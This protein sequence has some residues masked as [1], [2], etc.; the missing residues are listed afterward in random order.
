MLE[1]LRSIKPTPDDARVITRAVRRAAEFELQARIA[2]AEQRPD[3]AAANRSQ[4]KLAIGR[5]RRVGQAAR[6]DAEAA[7]AD[8]VSQAIDFLEQ[9]AIEGGY[10][11]LDLA[12]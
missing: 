10:R 2:T 1:D 5:L 6:I 3:A 8:R 7:A 9:A 11:L 4:Q 12:L